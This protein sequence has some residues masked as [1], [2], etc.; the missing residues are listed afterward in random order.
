[1]SLV[2]KG[3][4]AGYGDALVVDDVSLE[5]TAGTCLALLGANGAGKTSLLRVAAGQIA[6]RRGRVLLDGADITR[7]RG[8]DRVRQGL[9]YVPEKGG[10]FPR[11]TVRDNLLVFAGPDR[12]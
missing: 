8:H 12:R 3:V 1:M 2:F 4:S 5:V 6:P 10:T 7:L 11:L 9:C